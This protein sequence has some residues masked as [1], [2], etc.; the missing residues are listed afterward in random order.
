MMCA[1]DVTHGRYLSAALVFRGKVSSYEVEKQMLN[2]Q[3]KNSS[4]FTEW[5]PNSMKVSMCDISLDQVARSAVLIGNNT[6]IQEIF[7]RINS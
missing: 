1:A 7:K 6:S 4:Y 3:K 2:F 5:I